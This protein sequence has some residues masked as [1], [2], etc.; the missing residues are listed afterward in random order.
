MQW[1]ISQFNP[2]WLLSLEMRAKESIT[3]PR[4]NSNSETISRLR[5]YQEECIAQRRRAGII[6]G[7]EIYLDDY[8]NALSDTKVNRLHHGTS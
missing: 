4:E 6:N 3:V 2:Y 7:E 1:F 5:D 8:L